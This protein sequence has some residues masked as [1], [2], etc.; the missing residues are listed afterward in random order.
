M[1]TS[2]EYGWKFEARWFHHMSE[3]FSSETSNPKQTN[4]KYCAPFQ[5]LKTTYCCALST[6]CQIKF[7]SN[8]A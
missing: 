7:I 4:S 5:V 1:A 3:T 2:A 8:S 6:V